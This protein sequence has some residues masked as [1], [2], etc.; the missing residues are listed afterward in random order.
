MTNHQRRKDDRDLDYA[1]ARSYISS[2]ALFIGISA[3]IVGSWP[4]VAGAAI[5]IFVCSAEW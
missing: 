5:V 2:I 3:A 4:T 1:G